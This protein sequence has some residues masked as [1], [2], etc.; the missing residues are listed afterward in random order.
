MAFWQC[1]F[2]L[3]EPNS[4]FDSGKKALRDGHGL[5]AIKDGDGEQSE[6]RNP[7]GKTNLRVYQNLTEVESLLVG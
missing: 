6:L 4:K 3:D 2:R 7:F 1:R 5:K